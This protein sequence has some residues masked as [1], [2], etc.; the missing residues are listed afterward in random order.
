MAN[1]T[2]IEYRIGDATKPVDSRPKVIVH[3]CNNRR[4]WGLG[5]VLALSR[6]WSVTRSTYLNADMKLGSV[7]F[8]QVEDDIVVANII[9]QNGYGR[10]GK[11]VVYEAL[12]KGFE[13]VR[14]HFK[15]KEF[16]VHAPRLGTGL[17]GGEWSMISKLLETHFCAHGIKVVIYDLQ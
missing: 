11:F 16:S 10:R 17:A 13:S 4:A 1:S 6:K 12:G 8:A 2:K 9:G 7:S 5:F 3:C 15:N 14:S